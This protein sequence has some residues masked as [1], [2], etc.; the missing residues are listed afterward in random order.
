MDLDGPVVVDLVVIV[1]ADA[2]VNGA[3]VVPRPFAA[4]HL[5]GLW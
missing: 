5:L 1:D 4:R 2:D 3:S